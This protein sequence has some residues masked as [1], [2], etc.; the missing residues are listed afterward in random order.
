MLRSKKAKNDGNNKAPYKT[1]Y[2]PEKNPFKRSTKNIQCF[3]CQG[4]GHIAAKCANRKEKGKGKA[5][6]VSWE[7]DIDEDKS[8][9][10]SPDNE[11]KTSV[12]FMALFIVSSMQGSS[13]RESKFDKT[14]D[15]DDFFDD[16][17]DW[18]TTYKKLLQ[19]SIR[20]SRD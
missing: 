15:F 5:L 13:H 7:E 4:Y 11:F 10:E 19:D 9:P 3:E 20:M 16:D 14:L 8:D 2:V 12:A 1:K 18:E 6:N 17:K